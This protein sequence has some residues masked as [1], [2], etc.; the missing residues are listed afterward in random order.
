[1]SLMYETSSESRACTRV[2][3][4]SLM[5]MFLCLQIFMQAESEDVPHTCLQHRW[6]E[7]DS[8]V[9]ICLHLL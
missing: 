9:N 6:S 8:L 7:A 5:K 1:M 4:S 3:S 2:Q